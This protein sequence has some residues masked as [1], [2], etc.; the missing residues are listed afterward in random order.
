MVHSLHALDE[1]RESFGTLSPI[2]ARFLDYVVESPER[3]EQLKRI[4]D[5]LPSWT[6]PYETTRLTWPTFV[7]PGKLPQI[8]HATESICSLVKTLPERVFK[9]D[10]QKI[11]D[12][13][14][15]GDALLV[16]LLMEQPNGIKGAVGR[17]DFVDGP[18]GFKCCEINMAANIGGWR[19]RFWIEKYLANPVVSDFISSAGIHAVHH[20]PL[21]TCCAH[22]VDDAKASG[23]C[24]DGTL[25]VVVVCP[26][27]SVPRGEDKH[28]AQA[29]YSD[30]MRVSHPELSGKVQFCS[31][32]SELQMKNG[33]LF[34]ENEIIHAVL[35]YAGT[36]LPKQVYWSQKAGTICL[37]N[38]SL[39]KIMSDKRNLALLSEL[40]HTDL[41][42][43]A[44]RKVI[45]D[46]IP[47]SR[48][49]IDGK[50]TYHDESVSLPDFLISARDRLV[51]KLGIG[52]AGK[53]V[54]VGKFTPADE[55]NEC[56]RTALS[57]GGWIVQEYLESHPYIFADGE[58][59]L[60]TQDIVWGMF[61][62]GN[63]YGGGYLRML[64][65]GVRRGVVNTTGGA[66]EGPIFEVTH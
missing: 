35:N 2:A 44:E 13:Y 31:Q 29:I 53:D 14:N 23:V 59:A 10:P 39:T 54:N 48:I 56:V 42:D 57:D 4:A 22:V 60:Q 8:K 52:F 19:S 16:E 50:T 7:G 33:R 11:S 49:V 26:P 62:F 15:Y 18:A 20:D 41:F 63:R 61:C 38:G 28:F 24:T 6:R 65:K 47:W 1:A 66:V 37:Y 5:D 17:C 43:D 40:E 45:R 46:H 55:W 51:L 12:F 58:G 25:N 34:H 3:I 64:P 36:I 9:G 21:A 27:H 32:V 30:L